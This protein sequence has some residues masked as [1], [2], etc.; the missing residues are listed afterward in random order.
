[1]AMKKRHIKLVEVALVRIV[2]PPSLRT[3][4]IFFTRQ[5]EKG[6][7][8]PYDDSLVVKLSNEDCMV[9]RVL[10]KNRSLADIIFLKTL[11][12]MR[13][14]IN[15]IKK[16]KDMNLIV[17]AEPSTILKTMLMPATT[18]GVTMY[19]T[20]MVVDLLSTYNV[21]LRCPC[22]HDMKAVPFMYHHI[23]KFFNG[24]RIALLRSNK[25][26]RLDLAKLLQ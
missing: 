15:N 14:D 5:D 12:K 18:K 2:S 11:K 19:S 20:M 9:N 16:G 7:D 21:I 6:L 22:I 3:P 10:I 24:R 8:S 25:N 4:N 13:Y 17:N 26:K 1:M 23:L